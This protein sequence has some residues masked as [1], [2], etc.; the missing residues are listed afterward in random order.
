MMSGW[1]LGQARLAGAAAIVDACVGR[2]HVFLMGP[3]VNQR[4]Q[5]HAAFKFLFNSL[6]LAAAQEGCR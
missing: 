3:E 1:G 4:A 5:S 2:G 6:Y